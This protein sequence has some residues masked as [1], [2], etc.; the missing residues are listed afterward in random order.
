MEPRRRRGDGAPRGGEDGLVALAIVG[1]V[2]A[3]DIGR[4]GHVSHRV[5]ERVDV[6]R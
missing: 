2:A 5:D 4:K 6:L 3:M 1:R